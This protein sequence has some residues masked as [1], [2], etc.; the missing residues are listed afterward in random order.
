VKYF[1]GAPLIAAGLVLSLGLSACGG[2]GGGSAAVSGGG[3]SGSGN[4]G[5]TGSNTV[6]SCTASGGATP[7]S[8]SATSFNVTSNP[9]GLV[10][11]L[12]NGTATANVGSTPVTVTLTASILVQTITI[13]PTG[14]CYQVQVTANGSGTAQAL[15]FNKAAYTAGAVN[16]ASIQSA[17]RS[18]SSIDTSNVA[19]RAR[20]HFSGAPGIDQ[21]N[22]Y[23][24]YSVSALRA[25]GRSAQSIASSAGAR[26]TMQIA[27]TG[28]DELHAVAVPAGQSV[29][30]FTSTMRGQTAV[31]K[32]EPAHLRYHATTPVNPNDCHFGA[33][34]STCNPGPPNNLIGIQQQW[35]MSQIFAPYAWAYF[36]TTPAAAFAA[37]TSKIAIVDTGWDCLHTNATDD[38]TPNV[39][40]EAYYNSGLK[41]SSMSPF[42]CIAEDTDGH[43]SNVAGI[44]DAATN[45]GNGFAGVAANAQLYIYRIFP[46]GVNQS[47]STTDEAAAI[48]DAVTRGVKVINLS[49]GSPASSGPDA[50]EQAAIQ[51]ALNA[52]VSVVAAAGNDGNSSV[53]YPAAYSGVISV[54][55][56]SLADGQL[57]GRGNT[58]GSVVSPV[59]YIASY[60]NWGPNLTIVAPGGDPG[61]NG[62]DSDNLHWITNLYSTG[63]TTAGNICNP[64]SQPDRV[65]AAKFAGT[66]QATPHVAGA[67]ALM[68][69]ANA[70]LSSPQVLQILQSTSDDICSKASY[71]CPSGTIMEGK[72]R[73][74]VY[75]ALGAVLGQSV[76][77]TPVVNQFLAFAYTNTVPVGGTPV[78]INTNYK[79]GIPIGASGIFQMGDVPQSAT[80]YK[81]GV[82]YNA[83]GN[84]VV[85]VGDSFG[86]VNCS[87]QTACSAASNISVARV[88]AGQSF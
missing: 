47:A 37:K 24:H 39:V 28:D 17:L 42:T 33:S 82:W 15:F 32:V 3:S 63:D 31:T 25:A 12:N 44:A 9:S 38:F 77:Y 34:G 56:T 4:S 18:T 51:G 41:G 7:L 35:D 60:S 27:T 19:T 75:R 1:V 5:N 10:V 67:V 69:A 6:T 62:N 11:T 71:A 29:D 16:V 64:G 46:P 80:S 81:I 66:S 2:G 21:A 74:D 50:G 84:G 54:G 58:N 72:G 59:E 57:N 8:T 43:G 83:A 26:S 85:T 53:D 49:L 79:N 55:A 48:N 76:P 45:N 73:L 30:A 40:F 86:F 36:G 13:D 20:A 22:I 70:S 78:P 87:G 52:G 14:S 65:C 61:S 68:I 88:T 23:V